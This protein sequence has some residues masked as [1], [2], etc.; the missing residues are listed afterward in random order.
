[1]TRTGMNGDPEDIEPKKFKERV[2]EKIGLSDDVKPF[3]EKNLPKKG[4]PR[5]TLRFIRLLSLWILAFS[6]ISSFVYSIFLA[7]EPFGSGYNPAIKNVTSFALA[8]ISLSGFLMLGIA[9]E[10]KDRIG[11]IQ[12]IIQ[13]RKQKMIDLGLTESQA[14]LVEEEFRPPVVK[15]VKFKKFFFGMAIIGL[16]LFAFIY[17][18]FDLR[19]HIFAMYGLVGAI[20]SVGFILSGFAGDLNVELWRFE[21]FGLH[22]HEAAVGIFF[23]LV[24]V[25]LMYNGAAIDK[26]LAAFYFFVGAFLIGRDWKD[27]ANGRIIERTRKCDEPNK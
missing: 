5:S 9:S 23:I 3:N 22:I 20:I 11:E 26:I 21:I 6:L 14:R 2:Q 16:G 1:M 17:F 18:V 19:Y 15:G 12:K 27:M 4:E 10:G 24:G 25:P 8:F 7:A 13:E